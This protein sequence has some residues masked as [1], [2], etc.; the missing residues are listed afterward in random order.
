M[1][2]YSQFLIVC[3]VFSFTFTGCS[4]HMTSVSKD[5]QVSPTF[6]VNNYV[7]VGEEGR[8][9]FIV[10]PFQSKKGELLDKQP[11]IAGK[12]SKFMWH[13]WGKPE[14]LKGKFKVEAV[15][16]KGER[17]KVLIINS[18]K[19]YEFVWHYPSVGGR[20]NGA[21]AH[22]PSGMIFPKEAG[23]WR[24]NVYIG[25]ELFGN[26]VVEVEK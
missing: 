14:E 10:G 21:D 9:G 22:V 19:T 16:Q 26:I 17:Q 8:L 5:W 7:M 23:L 13:L 11:F 25:N 18:K 3:L 24:L 20:N 4:T 1:K 12:G 2:K 15:N 6:K